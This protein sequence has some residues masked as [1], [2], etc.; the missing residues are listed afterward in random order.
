M[1]E[2]EKTE[3]VKNAASVI[4]SNI[5]QVH[6]AQ[7]NFGHAFNRARQAI[8]LNPK[9]HKAYYRASMAL[10]RVHKYQHAFMV[11]R[12]GLSVLTSEASKAERT[13]MLELG[14]KVVTNWR[15]EEEAHNAKKERKRI[16]EEQR[17]A[18]KTALDTVLAK[19]KIN[20]GISQF[21]NTDAGYTGKIYVDAKKQ[22]HFPVVMLYPEAQQ[23][24]FLQDV[25]EYTTFADILGMM[26]PPNVPGAPWD[27]KGDYVVGNLEVYVKV[28]ESQSWAEDTLRV[29]A[30]KGEKIPIKT[31][32]SIGH[33]LTA[34]CKKGYVVPGFPT[35]CVAPIKKK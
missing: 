1:P 28:G 33:A 5:T 7:E 26:F 12:K 6:L 30:E 13:A 23:S 27:T 34:A 14:K 15:R 17:L 16:A 20:V 21:S 24:D 2:E 22:L 11:L 19:R 32:T 25:D 4:Y 29:D 10:Y 8:R 35:F 9:N 3:E 18:E 31:S